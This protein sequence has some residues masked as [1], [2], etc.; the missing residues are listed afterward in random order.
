MASRLAERHIELNAQLRART[1]A[2]LTRIWNSL[3]EYRDSTLPVWLQT[4]VPLVQAA[5]RSE[6]AITQA[7]LA[8]ALDR[9]VTG[10]DA[11]RIMEQYRNGTPHEDV[12]SR[13]FSAVWTALAAGTP[14][15]AAR[16]QGLARATQT[17]ATDIQMAMRDTLTTAGEADPDIWG[18]ERVADGD[19]CAFCLELDGAQFRTDSPL[20]IHPNCGCGV[21][22]I[23]Y[24]RGYDNRNNLKT[25]ENQPMN[26]PPSDKVTIRQHGELG[27]VITDPAHDFSLQ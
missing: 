22:P 11:D 26:R 21:E 23:V 2:Q 15:D 27:P 3:P 19:A 1:V 25:F 9:P 6:I 4:A 20:E 14:F 8:R 7:Y 10:L 16:E 24:T 13:P 12:Y 18:Y 5:Q 17:A